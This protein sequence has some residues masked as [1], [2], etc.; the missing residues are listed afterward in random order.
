MGKKA[1][2]KRLR[3]LAE[4]MPVVTRK[5]NET[6]VKVGKDLLKAGVITTAENLPVE[7]DQRYQATIKK[8]VP[9]NHERALKKIM[10]RNGFEGVKVYINSLK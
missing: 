5:E 3:A 4:S 2:Y 8:D 1:K 6:V 9:V 7:P 10:K